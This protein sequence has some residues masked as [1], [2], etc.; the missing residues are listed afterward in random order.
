MML[1]ATSLL[2]RS[3]ARSLQPVRCASTWGW[4]ALV[5]PQMDKEVVEDCRKLD[6]SLSSRNSLAN[7]VP[8]KVE[9]IDWAHWE[10]AIR[11]P[12]VVAEIKK[13]YD[14][15]QY[16]NHTIAEVKDILDENAAM[17]E[18]S[19]K[20]LPLY[21][22]EIAA[23]TAKVEEYK[24]AKVASDNWGLKE[25][26]NFMPGVEEQ[27]R[28]EAMR[29]EWALDIKTENMENIDLKEI[30]A[31]IKDGKTPTF[32][33]LPVDTVGDLDPIEEEELK[34]KGVWSIARQGASKEQRDVIQEKVQKLI[35]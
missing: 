10:K 14:A 18:E 17:V 9:T 6:S 19:K 33:E 3:S 25:W 5:G 16:T 29:D 8:K 24:K 30:I 34:S 27:F 11:A 12:G 32:P 4:E 20:K 21:K 13:E 2:A 15:I 28:N 1:R 23:A 31:Q 26:Y 35:A 7:S 22:H